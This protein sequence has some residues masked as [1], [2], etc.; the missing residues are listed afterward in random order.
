MKVIS[1][2]KVK[3]QSLKDNRKN[4]RQ[5]IDCIKGDI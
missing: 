1:A 2:I 5:L 4:L 3:T